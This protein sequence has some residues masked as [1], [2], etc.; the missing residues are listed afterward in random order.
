MVHFLSGSAGHRSILLSTYD[1]SSPL[2][3]Y[4]SSCPCRS[5][6]RWNHSL[7]AG[8]GR[9]HCNTG[10]HGPNDGLSPGGAYIAWPPCQ[11]WSDRLIRTR[12]LFPRTL[13]YGPMPTR[14]FWIFFGPD[15]VTSCVEN[16]LL[17]YY[18]FLH[19]KRLILT[20]DLLKNCRK[21]IE[22]W[23]RRFFVFLTIM[24]WTPDE[25]HIDTK[26]FTISTVSLAVHCIKW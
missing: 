17:N 2:R 16:F 25:Y 26:R 8:P 12:S 19:I 11:A 1:K 21:K 24:G 9:H 6:S 23:A 5:S 10:N 22:T 7:R 13:T 20:Q 4:H 14:W 3:H 18:F 15:M